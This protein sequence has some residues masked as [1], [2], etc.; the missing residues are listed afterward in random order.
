MAIVFLSLVLLV[1]VA[2]VFVGSR[3]RVPSRRYEGPASVSSLYDK[4]TNERLLEFYWGEHLHA[5]YYGDPPVK[6]DFI[7]AKIDMIDEMIKW[8]IAAPTTTFFKRLELTE[9]SDSGKVKIL[10]VGCGIGGS[11]RHL[12]K[13]WPKTSDVTGITIS[14][15]QAKH[16]ASLAR[17]QRVDNAM[18]LECDAHDLPFSDGS[19]EIVW[20]VESEHYMP[21]KEHFIREMVRVLKPGGV[22]IIAAWNVRD[23]QTAPLSDSERNIVQFLL[24]E[25]CMTDFISIQEYVD[26]YK[27]NGLVEVLSDDWAV[28]TQPS[29]RHAVT[30]A[31][32]DPRGWMRAKP[33]QL[34][35]LAR[36][37]YTIL[38]LG[39]AFRKGLC[40]YGLIRGQ[41]AES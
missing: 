11:T 40:Q 8:G 28:S 31:L 22:L 20:A 23:T 35:G 7:A 39:G 10:D 25:W 33:Y 38:R 14:E 17:S 29:W 26:L 30:V 15:A 3:L 36:D 32:Q 18:F 4:W 12:A 5:G 2:W 27:R 6:K 13:R 21:N 9:N 16:A 37:A 24:D 41:K 1:T 34:W 19:F